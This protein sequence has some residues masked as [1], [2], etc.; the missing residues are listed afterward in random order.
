VVDEIIVIEKPELKIILAEHGY[1]QENNMVVSSEVMGT[2][3]GQKCSSVGNGVI[4]FE[5]LTYTYK[6][7][8]HN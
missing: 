5:S 7:C 1:R 3:W 6:Y 4:T 8:E 2:F